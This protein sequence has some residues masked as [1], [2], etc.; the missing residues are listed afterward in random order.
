MAHELYSSLPFLRNPDIAMG[1]AVK[2]LLDDV[3]ANETAE[4][5]ATRKREFPLSYVPFATH[6]VQ[7]LDISYAFFQALSA[8]IQSLD[9]EMT[10]SEKAVWETASQYL[11][12]RK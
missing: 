7:D 1:I 10:A 9:K 11:E 2:T 5:R 6:F 12:L 4:A 3:P 8:G